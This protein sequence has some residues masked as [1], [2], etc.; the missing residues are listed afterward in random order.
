MS[1]ILVGHGNFN[2]PEMESYHPEMGVVAI[3]D[4][5]T[6]QFFSEITQVTTDKEALGGWFQDWVVRW[7][8]IKAGANAPLR[9][10]SVTPNFSL[11]SIFKRKGAARNFMKLCEK[12]MPDE[13]IVLADFS[14][15]G[16]LQMCTGNPAICPTNPKK[17]GE[18]VHKCNGILGVYAGE[19]L[20]WAACTA[21][22]GI[23]I[24]KPFDTSRVESDTSEK[25]QQFWQGATLSDA[26]AYD[27]TYMGDNPDDIIAF[28]RRYLANQGEGE[29]KELFLP[30]LNATQIRR[31]F[32]D[33]FLAKKLAESGYK[34]PVKS[35]TT[36][37]ANY[38]L[39]MLEAGTP[40]DEVR[41]QIM[42]HD[43]ETFNSIYSNEG[44][45]GWLGT[46][47]EGLPPID[48]LTP[49]DVSGIDENWADRRSAEQFALV[50]VESHI[51]RLLATYEACPADPDELRVVKEDLKKE[52]R[53][54][55]PLHYA[56][57]ICNDPR[58]WAILDGWG[59]SSADF[60]VFYDDDFIGSL[61]QESYKQMEEDSVEAQ[62]DPMEDVD[63]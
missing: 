52:I 63:E 32:V 60:D 61:Q 57:A 11:A 39:A 45:R 53:S 26:A 42:C 40:P 16:R 28:A 29:F 59:P 31:L 13:E 9:K 46:G 35:D 33:P 25:W 44:I 34:Q 8:A 17:Q 49:I 7:P 2:P 41:A 27:W 18:W 51:V 23:E 37:W 20:Y 15:Q 30:T 38:Y 19:D 54:C 24:S 43:P 12:Y 47:T 36:T 22:T 48:A 5:L 56:A 1:I 21:V 4:G 62:D 3:P 55:I 14:P 6:L 58:I 10:G 50:E